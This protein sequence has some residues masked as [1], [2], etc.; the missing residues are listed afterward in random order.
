MDG[1]GDRSR[2]TPPHPILGW[3]TAGD[4][5]DDLAL[6]LSRLVRQRTAVAAGYGL[7]VPPPTAA[8]RALLLAAH[9]TMAAQTEMARGGRLTAAL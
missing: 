8:G 1:S 3:L 2:L 5:W 4:C 6:Q 7:P 9:R